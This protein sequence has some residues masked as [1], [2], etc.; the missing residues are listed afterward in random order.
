MNEELLKVLCSYR[1]YDSLVIAELEEFENKS[2]RLVPHY[3]CKQSFS[4]VTQHLIDYVVEHYPYSSDEI[5]LKEFLILGWKY[6]SKKREFEYEKNLLET[7]KKNYEAAE[8]F[9]V[10]LFDGQ[11]VLAPK[12]TEH[13]AMLA[14]T[15]KIYAIKEYRAM[16]GT[17]LA[18]SKA[19]VEACNVDR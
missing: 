1:S 17:G 13:I 9:E 11:K 12:P 5:H 14:R 7:Q 8:K 10:F 3:Q 6:L 16:F 2:Y 18:E 19:A 4:Y 15:N